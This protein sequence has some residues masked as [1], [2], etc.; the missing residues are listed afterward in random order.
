VPARLR[1]ALGRLVG[2]ERLVDELM[3]DGIDW[4]RTTAFPLP[5]DGSAFVRLNLA[6]REPRGTVA[7]GDAYNELC[8]EICAALDELRHAHTGEPVVARAAR[9]DE[10]FGLP[11]DGPFP[12]LCIQWRRLPRV[13]AVRSERLGTIT[14]A[15]DGPLKSVQTAPGFLLGRAPGLPPSGS[16]RL[17]GSSAR[18]AD[19]AATALEWLGVTPPP[20]ISG[21]PIRALARP[22]AQLAGRVDGPATRPLAAEEARR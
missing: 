3:L 1:P 22:V 11:A 13:S 21:R 20:E 8:A 16:R 9:F 14:V 19:V 2:R 18:L 10:L 5:A 4:E 15:A 17:V 12:D 6:G 7:P